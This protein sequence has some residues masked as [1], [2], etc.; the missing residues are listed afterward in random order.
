MTDQQ[1]IDG[2]LEGWEDA[3]DWMKTKQ[4]GVGI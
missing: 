1:F 4:G 2:Y 3:L